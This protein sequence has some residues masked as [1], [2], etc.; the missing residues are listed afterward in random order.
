MKHI[1]KIQPVENLYN[2]RITNKVKKGKTTKPP[3]QKPDTFEREYNQLEDDMGN[4]Q[5]EW[6]KVQFYPEDLAKLKTMSPEE[7]VK[8]AQFLREQKR[9]NVIKEK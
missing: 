8:Y 6:Q 2:R 3:E 5:M 9:Y 7:Q 1:L 4:V